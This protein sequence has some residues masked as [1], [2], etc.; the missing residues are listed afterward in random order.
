MGTTIKPRSAQVVIYQGDDLQRLTD[1]RRDAEVKQRIAD[2]PRAETAR[3]G[4][5]ATPQ[6][7]AQAARDAYDAFVAEAAGRAVTVEVHALPRKKF[8]GLMADHAPRKVD[9]E[10]GT[11]VTHADDAPFDVN[12][13]TFGEPFLVASIF[14]PQFDSKAEAVDFLDSLSEGEFDT[15]FAAAYLLNRSPIADPRSSRYSNASLSTDAI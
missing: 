3:A 7:D 12:V 9:G 5:D 13:D 6:A 10:D 15:L 2:R 14:D 4:D 1:L 11:Q 8:R